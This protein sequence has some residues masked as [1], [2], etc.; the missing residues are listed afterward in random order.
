MFIIDVTDISNDKVK[1]RVNQ[2]TAGNVNIAGASARQITG[3]TFIRLGD[4]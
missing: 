4:T 2:Q 1:F 3:F